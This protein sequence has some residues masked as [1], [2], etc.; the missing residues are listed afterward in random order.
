MSVFGEERVFIEN[1]S[2]G[3]NSVLLYIRTM[4]KLFPLFLAK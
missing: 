4:Q 1:A 2:R 3:E